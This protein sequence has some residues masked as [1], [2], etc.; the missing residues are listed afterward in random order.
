MK[1]TYINPTIEVVKIATQHMLAG[2]PG[3]QTLNPEDEQITNENQVGGRFF[4]FEEEEY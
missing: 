3:S 2:S 4:E 1:K